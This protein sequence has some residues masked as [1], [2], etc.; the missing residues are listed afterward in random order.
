MGHAMGGL[1]AQILAS[2]GLVKSAALL[3]PAFP[4]G[5]NALKYSMITAF[6]KVLTHWG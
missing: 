5:V 4:A 6:G 1:L 3:T 2:R